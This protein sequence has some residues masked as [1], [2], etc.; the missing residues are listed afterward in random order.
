MSHHLRPLRQVLV[1][2]ER[3]D[4]DSDSKDEDVPFGWHVEWPDLDIR[5]SEQGGGQGGLGVFASRNLQPW[6]FIPIFG[7]QL[8]P[9]K[10]NTLLQQ[11]LAT[12]VFHIGNQLIDGHPRRHPSAGVGGHGL[13]IAALV[14]EPT[15]CK[16]N[17]IIR[18]SRLVVARA[19]PQGAELLV[20]YGP[21]YQRNYHV[22]RFALVKQYYPALEH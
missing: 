11:Q 16:P 12:H 19:I 8:S 4:N 6:E 13:Y 22:S 15:R 1:E 14:N 3:S 9:E 7:Q 17:V 20:S 18:G 10:Y 2:N 5:Q 21:E